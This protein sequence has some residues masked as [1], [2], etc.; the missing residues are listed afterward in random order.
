MEDGMNRHWWLRNSDPELVGRNGKIEFRSID[1]EVIRRF[2]Y[3]FGQELLF[4]F[5]VK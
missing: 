3:D 5:R 1:G 4:R 2:P